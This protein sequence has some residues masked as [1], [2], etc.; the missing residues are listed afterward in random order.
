[1]NP[2]IAYFIGLLA[3]TFVTLAAIRKNE[4]PRD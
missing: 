1:M 4:A 2:V 3:G